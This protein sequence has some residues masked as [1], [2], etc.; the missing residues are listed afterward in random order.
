MD[1]AYPPVDIVEEVDIDQDTIQVSSDTE[2]RIKSNKHP[3]TDIQ[4][5]SSNT[6]TTT[7]TADPLKMFFDT[8]YAT[9][10]KMP[11]EDILQARRKVFDVIAE[12]EEQQHYRQLAAQNP[13]EDLDN[14]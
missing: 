5:A 13:P 7:I 12:I 10:A 14:N 1:W 6:P 8:M 2:S 4:A 9:V 11:R 3:K